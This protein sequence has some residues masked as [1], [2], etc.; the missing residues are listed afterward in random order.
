MGQS[1]LSEV[2]DKVNAVMCGFS[3]AWV[4]DAEKDQ[5][6]LVRVDFGHPKLHYF[7]PVLN[8]TVII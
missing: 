6:G 3:T 4:S 5:L 8:V 1:L 7:Y 2:S